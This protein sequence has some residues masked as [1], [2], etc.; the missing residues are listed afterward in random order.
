[1]KAAKRTANN[2]KKYMRTPTLEDR[3]KFLEDDLSDAL[4][5]LFVGAVVWSAADKSELCP[6]QKGLGMFTSLVQ[7]RSLYEFY[8]SKRATA[9]DDARAHDFAPSWAGRE[10]ALYNEY[11]VKGK[12]ANKRVFH[13]VYFRS[14]R[15]GG[16]T[17]EHDGP[18]HI[19]NRILEFAK[20]LRRLTEEFIKCVEP[21]FRD[22]VER[23]LEKALKGADEAANGCDIANPL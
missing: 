7:A 13:L 8:S 5:G 16:P 2:T 1:M 9:Y 19:K 11:M 17:N 12:P 22:S 10:S 20:D 23:G 6:F 14:E 18:K 21:H 3:K 4:K 15:S